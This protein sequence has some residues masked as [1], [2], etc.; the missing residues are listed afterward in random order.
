[1]KLPSKLYLRF[2]IPMLRYEV[3]EENAS[4]AKRRIRTLELGLMNEQLENN[5]Y[6]D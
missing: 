3:I 5:F 4:E 2:S 1:M 6:V